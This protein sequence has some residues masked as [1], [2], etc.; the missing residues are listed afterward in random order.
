M[1]E[2]LRL[3][4]R[5]ANVDLDGNKPIGYSLK[6]IKG[7]S[8]SFASAVCI[9][10]N[11]ERTKKTGYLTDEEVKRLNDAIANPAKNKIPLWMLNRRLDYETGENKHLLA[12][13]LEFTKSNDIRRYKKIKSRRGMR[14]AAGLPVRGQKTK[15]HFRTG[16]TL[17][18]SRAKGSKTGK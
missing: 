9:Q 10:A 15:A 16:A 6:K 18:V 12:A 7:I 11:V 4:V 3:I 2:E 13:D 17:G 14:H 1:A 5:V 8:F